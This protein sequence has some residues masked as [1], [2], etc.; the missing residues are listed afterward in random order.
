MNL[1]NA[2]RKRKICFW[3]LTW[4]CWQP[5]V[6]H[7]K[8]WILLLPWKRFSCS[9]QWSALR[10]RHSAHIQYSTVWSQWCTRSYFWNIVACI[11]WNVQYAT[12]THCNPQ[13]NALNPLPVWRIT[14]K[15]YQLCFFFFTFYW[16]F[17]TNAKQ[18][19]MHLTWAAIC[20]ANEAAV[21]QLW[22]IF[23]TRL[24]TWN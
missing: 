13:C 15:C 21:M 2:N 19:L 22:F 18:L 20:N 5:D 17:I 10:H 3:R 24:H 11:C 16:G 7:G 4:W 23:D 12:R 1:G 6:A 14:L 9:D 8:A